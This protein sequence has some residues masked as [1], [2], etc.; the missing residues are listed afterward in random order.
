MDAFYISTKLKTMFKKSEENDI[1][2]S[3]WWY[4]INLPFDILRN[5]SIPSADPDDWDKMRTIVVVMLIP[6]AFL[7]LDGTITSPMDDDERS[8]VF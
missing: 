8:K 5:I 4:I 2:K 3:V 1:L 7:I 6:T